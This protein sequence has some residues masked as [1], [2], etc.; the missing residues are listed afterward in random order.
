MSYYESRYFKAKG[1]TG[2]E[3]L[4][5]NLCKQECTPYLIKL[6]Q[7]IHWFITVQRYN[8]T[9]IIVQIFARKNY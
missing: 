2:C 4:G 5:S 3:I 1:K 6:Q 8:I 9:W 7:K